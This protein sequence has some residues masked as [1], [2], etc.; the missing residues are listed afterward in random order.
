M[1]NFRLEYYNDKT[2]TLEVMFLDGE[3]SNDVKTLWNQKHKNKGK[4]MSVCN[5]KTYKEY[6]EK[7]GALMKPQN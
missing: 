5:S 3:D 2:K 6:L 1:V 7:Y 4:L